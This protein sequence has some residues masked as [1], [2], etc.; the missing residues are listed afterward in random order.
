MSRKKLKTYDDFKEVFDADVKRLAQLKQVVE[1][2]KPIVDD[3]DIAAVVA[4]RT[5][6][7]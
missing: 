3:A 4:R 2:I 1:E 5:E 6:F 7:R